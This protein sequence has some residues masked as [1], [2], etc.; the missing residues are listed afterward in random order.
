MLLT[1]KGAAGVTGSGFV[2]LVATLTIMPD[3][4]VAGVAIIVGID[5]FMSEARAL[6]SCIS[7]AV[8][9]VVVSIWE[10]ACDREVLKRELD[11]NYA[12]TEE[13]LEEAQVKNAVTP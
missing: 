11:Q 3:V 10:N 5:R 9:V 1:S 4:P 8:A 7:N 6:T 2:A 12:N 13:A